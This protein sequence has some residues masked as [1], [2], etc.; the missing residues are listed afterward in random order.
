MKNVKLWKFFCMFS[1]IGIPDFTISFDRFEK[2]GESV[3]TDFDKWSANN[4]LWDF[5]THYS[6]GYSDAWYSVDVTRANKIILH[7]DGTNGYL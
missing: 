5:Q 1:S 6:N 2:N 3:T 4:Y 7:N